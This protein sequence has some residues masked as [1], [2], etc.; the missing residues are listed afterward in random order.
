MVFMPL[1]KNYYYRFGKNRPKILESPIY[2][3]VK[4]KNKKELVIL[5]KVLP[6]E[7]NVGYHDVTSRI[8][9]KVNGI[10]IIDFKDFVNK[11]DSVVGEYL[12]IEDNYFQKYI[13]KV[14]D[15]KIRDEIILQ[16]YGINSAMNINN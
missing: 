1:T 10:K 12:I 14:S 13:F 16:K 11:V 9:E 8:V 3:S 15:L 4:N 5:T 7:C 6:D 2:W